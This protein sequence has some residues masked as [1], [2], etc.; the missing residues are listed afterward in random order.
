V[1]LMAFLIGFLMGLVVYFAPGGR[2]YLE[3]VS[4]HLQYLTK[5]RTILTRV[6]G[7]T[8]FTAFWP[9]VTPWAR[10]LGPAPGPIE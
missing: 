4:A 2:G 8:R 3:H 7:S 9:N 10:T 1:L 5:P 6:S